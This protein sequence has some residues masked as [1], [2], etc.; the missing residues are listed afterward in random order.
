MAT[1]VQRI[2]EK[3][4]F[5]FMRLGRHVFH[6]EQSKDFQADRAPLKS[7]HHAAGNGDL[8][9]NQGSVG[10]CTANALTTAIMLDPDWEVGD[11]VRT[12]DDAVNLYEWETA[13]EGT[14]W[15]PSAPTVNDVGG[16]GLM[17]S[18][19]AKQHGWIKSYKHAFGI[20]HSL[21][22]LA[23]RPCIFGVTWY[24]SMFSPGSDGVITVDSNSGVAGGHEICA[25]ELDVEGQRVGFWNSWGAGWGLGGR[26][27]VH[28]ADLNSLLMQYGDC[29]TLHR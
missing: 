14:P 25:D 18:K 5:L 26:F 11:P 15:L 2:E 27:Y 10:S 12:E 9:L 24:N 19:A 20:Q 1:L 28:W 29:T 16:S 7:I 8:P 21:E 17:V 13:L 22:A 6:D 4:P 23:L 3:D